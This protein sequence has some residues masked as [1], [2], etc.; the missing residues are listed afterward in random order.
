MTE[1]MAPD[2]T[3]QPLTR[4]AT[5]SGKL[6]FVAAVSILTLL[7]DP[8]QT[9]AAIRYSITRID[10]G[11]EGWTFRAFGQNDLGT[12]VGELDDADGNSHMAMWQSGVLTDY[13]RF[14]HQAAV[15]S[16]INNAG[17][18]IGFVQDQEPS[19]SVMEAVT[20]V[21]G[22]LT[23]LGT[24]NG[25]PS[26][27]SQSIAIGIDE[28][29]DIAGTSYDTTSG[30]VGH[31]VVWQGGVIHDL[32]VPIGYDSARTTGMNSAGQIIGVCTL[33]SGIRQ[34]SIWS[35]EHG[36][37]L[38]DVPPQVEYVS[39]A[40]IN[41]LG[42][43]VGSTYDLGTPYFYD[44]TGI[45]PLPLPPGVEKA[46][47]MSIND[48]DQIVGTTDLN[49][50]V[51]LLWENGNVYDINDLIPPDYGVFDGISEIS[52]NNAGQIIMT[53]V[54]VGQVESFVLTPLPEPGFAST[55]VTVFVVVFARRPR[56]R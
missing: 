4:V 5:F 55:T 22:T 53:E 50:S 36:F 25:P 6:P 16:R 40:G 43:V 17:Q 37:A 8:S 24:L 28:A 12:V 23:P 27:A 14:G 35:A 2:S 44:G 34:A 39:P 38:L 29:G 33:G 52:V 46:Q 21:A 49:V 26:L 51:P 13:G 10:T 30:W 3:L 19:Q 41:V 9:P 20:L 11:Q 42:H 18:M 47:G 48:E 56:R 32:G 1:E 15:L 45:V 54:T 7:M 31:Q